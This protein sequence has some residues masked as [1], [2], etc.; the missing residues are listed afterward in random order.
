M[1]SIIMLSVIMLSVFMLS[2]ILLSVILLS[3]ILLSVIILSVIIMSVIMLSIIMLSVCG[4]LS[5]VFALVQA[6]PERRRLLLQGVRPR[7]RQ[8]AELQRVLRPHEQPPTGV[9]RNPSTF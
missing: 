5:N 6:Q 9:R 4:M 2:V 8:P 3:V 7:P 1:L